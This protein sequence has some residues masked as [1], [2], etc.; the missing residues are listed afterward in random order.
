M[1]R[2][3]SCVLEQANFHGLV[4]PSV[5]PSVP[6]AALASFPSLPPLPMQQ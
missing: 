1:R 6:L 4:R 3:E 5:R 2:R